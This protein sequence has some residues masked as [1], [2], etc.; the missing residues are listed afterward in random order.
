MLS[1]SGARGIVGKS[2]TA[3][4]AARLAYTY[5]NIL[6]NQSEQSAKS[7]NTN[8]NPSHP[9]VVI[10]LDS[11]PSGQMLESAAIAG[12]HAAGCKVIRLGIEMTP[13]VA[14]MI[15]Q[16]KADGGI[17]ITASHNPSQWNGLKCLT[18]DGVAPPPE[19]AQL[20][21]NQFQ[22]NKTN[23]I[24]LADHNQ[25]SEI[26]NTGT[27][28]HVNMILE[29]IDVKNIQNA[30]FKVVLDSI[31]GAGCA[32]GRLLLDSLNVNLIHINNEPNGNFTHSPEPT[33][34][35]LTSLAQAVTENNADIGFAQDPDADRLAIIDEN[36][37]YI[38]EEF[39]LC[40]ASQYVL[41][42]INTNSKYEN[43]IVTNLSTSRMIDDIAAM[44]KAE[45]LRTSV[46][47][48]N[49]A[50]LMKKR[51][52]IIGGEGN[53][54]VIWPEICLVRDSLSGMALALNLMAEKQKTL[55]RIV[56]E[57]PAYIIKKIKVDIKPGLAEKAI[58]ILN[59]KF[60]H[61]QIDT[62]DGIRIDFQDIS[63]WIHVRASNTEP[64]LRIIVEAP[65]EHDADKLLKMTQDV[66]NT[67]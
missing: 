1:V 12:L 55:T 40:L 7:S 53:G 26:D 21:I 30:G 4:V 64:I 35:N 39:S 47:E 41:S 31:N 32:A 18:S 59:Q 17:V 48:A 10:G 11:R 19:Q 49:V 45:V 36:G 13:T 28:R 23:T 60:A 5:G 62:Q 57:I 66:I 8:E 24:S 25:V 65:T 46:G 16:Y 42:K 58:Q 3:E 34:E 43:S 56:S 22:T 9:L 54:G 2:M 38:G 52:S 67:I 14:V 33:C 61:Q 29:K 20:I 51:K 37:K 6:R 44:Y 50:A 63:S 27:Q 15:N